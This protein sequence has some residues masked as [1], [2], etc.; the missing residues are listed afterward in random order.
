[1]LAS[2]NAPRP[3]GKAVTL[4]ESRETL[5]SGDQA[6]PIS[7]AFG[8]APTTEFTLGPSAVPD[9]RVGQDHPLVSRRGRRPRGRGR[10]RCPAGAALRA[11]SAPAPAEWVCA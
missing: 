7:H 2:P 9:E 10:Y 8:T 5:A 11:R 1:M 4:P 6:E 3:P